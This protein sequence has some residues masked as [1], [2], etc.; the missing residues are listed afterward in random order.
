MYG[1]NIWQPSTGA[2]MLSSHVILDQSGWTI[3]AVSAKSQTQKFILGA[4]NGKFRKEPD[5]QKFDHL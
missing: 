1:K 3:D 4:S 5:H 2:G